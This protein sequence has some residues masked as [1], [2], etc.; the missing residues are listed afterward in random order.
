MAPGF[1]STAATS[2]GEVVACKQA[3][4]VPIWESPSLTG[5]LIRRRVCVQE[6]GGGG[7]KQVLDRQ[8]KGD[9]FFVLHLSPP[10]PP[11][12]QIF[13]WTDPRA[14]ST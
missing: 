4:G 14:E 12:F 10:P 1:V 9:V 13:Y 8:E 2:R 6:G 7:K 3:E 5:E 11:L